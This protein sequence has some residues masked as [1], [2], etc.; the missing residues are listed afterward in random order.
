MSDRATTWAWQQEP[1]SDKAWLALVLLANNA[2]DEGELT[3]RR[4]DFARLLRCS[5]DTFDRRVKSLVDDELLIVK[6][7]L[8]QRG[9]RANTYALA[10]PAEFARVVKGRNSAALKM[11]SLAAPEEKPE[12][13]H[14]AAEVRL[15]AS[16]AAPIK[17]S[18]NLLPLEI[19]TDRSE[20]SLPI[21]PYGAGDGKRAIALYNE[22]AKRA[23]WC[24]A[25]GEPSRER[26][27]AV[28]ARL[29]DGGGLQGWKETL[30]LAE[31][32][33]FLAGENDRGWRMGIDYFSRPSGWQKIVEGSF[34]TRSNLVMMTDY[35]S[36]SNGTRNYTPSLNG[37]RNND[38]RETASITTRVLQA[39][40]S[41][42]VG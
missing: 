15:A 21:A 14:V 9:N 10:I 39:G 6:P 19:H 24:Q 25:K 8:T 41:R 1:S 18:E 29:R 16:V 11:G 3:I 33:P 42:P 2:D 26:K 5:V 22:S 28:K 34:P 35:R 37:N 27:Q 36:E 20:S 7:N 12:Q 4:A 38:R 32:M 31:E 23:G 40:Y 30:A 17:D 13:N